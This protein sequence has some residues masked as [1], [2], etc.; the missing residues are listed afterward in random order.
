LRM[1]FSENR[2]PLFGIMRW[3]PINIGSPAAMK[4]LHLNGSM[5]WR[6]K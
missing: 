6:D 4:A 3:R 2:F 5:N 1:I